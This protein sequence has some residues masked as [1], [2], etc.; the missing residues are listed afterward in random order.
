[1]RVVR[2]GLSGALWLAATGLAAGL[3][4][5]GLLPVLD[6]AA[7]DGTTISAADLRR[8]PVPSAAPALAPSPSSSTPAPVGSGVGGAVGSPS[9]QRTSPAATG[10][11][12]AEVVDG[13][14]QV[15]G[16]D[17][18]VAYL[19]SF[20]VSG[21][22]ALIR[23]SPGHAAVVSATPASGYTVDTT[24]DEADHAVVQFYTASRMDVID[25][26]WWENRPYAQVSQ[27]Q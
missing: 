16:D 15:T 18:S 20:Q 12:P 19:H 8:A 4:W 21:G 26:V 3:I 9:P 10:G 14:Q 2:A 17:G 7:P 22:V 24:Q 6:T 23:E 13:W 5:V 1:M 11:H 27:V 25:A